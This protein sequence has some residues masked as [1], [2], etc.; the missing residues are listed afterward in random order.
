MKNCRT[1]SIVVCDVSDRRDDLISVGKVGK[2]D[3]QNRF[4]IV[5]DD[6]DSGAIWRKVEIADD[7]TDEVEV[8]PPVED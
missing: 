7:T 1:A 4:G 2:T 5:G 6:G 3:P 8:G